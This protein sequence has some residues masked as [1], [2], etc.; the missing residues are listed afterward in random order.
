MAS[1]AEIDKSTARRY[2]EILEDTLLI[3]RVDPFSRK[4][5]SHAVRRIVKH[6]KFFFFDQGVL[7]ALLQSFTADAIRNGLLFEHLIFNQMLSIAKGLDLFSKL[8]ISSYRTEHGAEVDF[9]VELKDQ[10]YAIEVKYSKNVG[11]N[12]L[13]GLES[14]SQYVGRKSIQKRVFCIDH[15][16]RKI[17]D[18]E[19]LPWKYGL[20]ELF[21]L[22]A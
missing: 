5:S 10:L 19:I 12:D 6:P 4:G 11:T 7:N 20:Q 15:T 13:R 9:V 16:K 8:K 22:A 3:Q 21:N 1:E 18:V 14:F 17:G 2:F